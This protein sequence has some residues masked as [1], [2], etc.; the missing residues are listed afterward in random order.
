VNPVDI[1]LLLLLGLSAGCLGG[2][3]GIGGSILI[4]PVLGLLLGHD[5]HVAQA[6]AM[7]VNVF[8]A[9]PATLQ[10]HR[11]RAVRWDVGKRMILPALVTIALGVESSN[12][13]SAARL[14]RVFGVFL[15]YVVIIN[16]RHLAG[17]AP[18]PAQ[19]EERVAWPRCALVGALMGFCAGLLG[20]GAGTLVVP[21]LQR[22][23]HL[24]FR[25]CIATST[26]VM[27]VTATIGA[28]HKNLTLNQTLDSTQ[29]LGDSLAVAAILAPTAVAGGIVGARLMHALPLFWVRLAFTLLIG[30]AAAHMLGLGV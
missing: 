18:E 11:A 19:G 20:I 17:R 23:C 24:P 1:L 16:V 8:V 22:V 30:W 3:L 26:A 21:L 10:H 12:W 13:L 28:V 2:V 9:L 4:I 29:A 15:V 5:Q 27:C 25:Q 7:I 6:A 14:E